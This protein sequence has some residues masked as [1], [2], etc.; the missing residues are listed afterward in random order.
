MR[1]YGGQYIRKQIKINGGNVDEKLVVDIEANGFQNTVTEVWCISVFN[2]KTKEKETFTNHDKNHRPLRDGLELL[3]N[4]S[5]IIGHNWIA[6]DQ[7]VLEKLYN[8]ETKATL[9]DTFLMSQLLDFNRKLGRVTG[10]HGL[11]FWGEHFGVQKPKQEQ[12]LKYEPAMLNR[13]EQDVLINVHTYVQLMKELKASKIPKDV[14]RREFAIAKISAEQVRNGWLIDERLAQRHVTFLKQETL[15]LKDKIEPLMPPIIKCPDVWVTNKE[16]NEMLGTEGVNYEEGL[17]EGKRLR[18]PVIPR[19]TKAGK[20]HAS[21]A[22]WL[23]EGNY[24]SKFGKNKVWGA[25]CRVDI[26]PAKLT[27]HA[28]VK[29]LLFKNGWKPTEWNTKRDVEGNYIKTSAKLTE[30]SYESIKGDLGQDIALHAT[31]QHRLNTLQNQKNDEKGWLGVR[32]EDGRLECVPFTLGTATGRMSHRNLVN[33]PGAG[34]TF[35]KEMREVFIAPRGKVLVGCDL[36]SAQLRLLA[37]AMGDESYSETVT[38]G[39]EADGTDVHTVNQKAAGLKSRSQAKTF[40][41]GFLF[42]AGDAKIGSITGGKAK[43]GK[44]LKAKFLKTF[45]ALSKLQNKLRLDFERSGKRHITAQDGRKIQVG[46][47]H[48]LLNYLLQGN[49]AILAKEWAIITDKLIKKNNIDC[50]LLAIVH[51]EQNFECSKED[52]PKLASILEKAAT[53]AGEKLGFKCRMDGTSK[54][55]G[56]WYEI[57]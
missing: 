4:A 57:H 15:R 56:N 32:R 25:Y 12:W 9:V 49:E 17:K 18:K 30:D 21:Q 26:I 45:P 47:E 53:M 48:K 37:A 42:G 28:E 8:F 40:I 10:R 22:N 31:Y 39:K 5:Q 55:G 3:A 16:C 1:D 2:I 7:V 34:A 36:A 23:R 44:A 33:V 52:A 38:T 20:L 41:Y 43:D 27:Q 54:I 19:Y 51:D 35:G 13:C 24:F 29:K 11:E 14:V 6:Y 46:S 50:K